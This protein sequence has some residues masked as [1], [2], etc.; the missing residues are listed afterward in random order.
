[1]KPAVERPKSWLRQ[2]ANA[3]GIDPTLKPAPEVVIDGF[4][5]ALGQFLKS[6]MIHKEEEN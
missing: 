1:M 6:Q 2:M 5:R 3:Q 4:S